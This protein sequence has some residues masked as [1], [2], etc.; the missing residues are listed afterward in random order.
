[1]SKD[2]VLSKYT[3]CLKIGDVILILK[4]ETATRR[5]LGVGKLPGK[6]PW[7]SSI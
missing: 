6:H 7:W 4:S 5:C 3:C 2:Y 1:M